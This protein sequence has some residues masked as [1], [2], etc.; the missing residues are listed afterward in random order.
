M[1]EV[2]PS[3]SLLPRGKQCPPSTFVQQ[4][5]LFTLFKVLVGKLSTAEQRR[6]K[7]VA[8]QRAKLLKYIQR[9]RLRFSRYALRPLSNPFFRHPICTGA[10]HAARLACCFS[11]W[12]ADPRVL[13]NSTSVKA[14]ITANTPAHPL[15][16]SSHAS[17]AGRA[18]HVIGVNA[19][20]LK[21]ISTPAGSLPMHTDA[22]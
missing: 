1:G 12:P 7:S 11:A 17:P 8:E 22:V 9:Q 3:T 10:P 6:H 5:R 20:G 19:S 14:T 18:F 2:L 13:D 21:P 4:N 15:V 16:I